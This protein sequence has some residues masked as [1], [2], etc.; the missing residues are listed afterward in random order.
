MPVKVKQA[1]SRDL[2]LSV[3]KNILFAIVC[4]HKIKHGMKP[5]VVEIIN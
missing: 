4:K 1:V 3:G 5:Q 2:F